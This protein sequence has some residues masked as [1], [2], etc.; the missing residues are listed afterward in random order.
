MTKKNA[1]FNTKHVT[2][3]V[4]LLVSV[5]LHA[6]IHEINLPNPKPAVPPPTFTA[7]Y[8]FQ[9]S[10]AIGAGVAE[11]GVQTTLANVIWDWGVAPPGGVINNKTLTIQG[12][13]IT[14]PADP[15]SS[16]G[17]GPNVTI[18]G[19]PNST[20]GFTFNLI[21]AD[22]VDPTNSVN[23]QFSVIITQ[24][25]DVA[26]VLDR[27]GS[28]N[29][30]TSSGSRWSALQQTVGNFMNLYQTSN[31]TD[32]TTVTYFSTDALPVSTCCG[33]LLANQSNDLKTKIPTEL[34]QPAFQPNGWTAMGKGMKNAQTKLSDATKAR[35]I[36]LITDGE[37]NQDPKVNL[38][39]K[40]YSDNTSIPGGPNPGGIRVCAIGIGSPSGLFHQ[41]LQNLA[42][43]NRGT[44]YVS[45]NGTAFTF[46]GGTNVGDMS[47]GFT[48]NFVQLLQNLSP[49]IIKISAD[50]I[51]STNTPVTLQTFALNKNVDKLMLEFVV[52]KKFEGSQIFQLLL[53]IKIMKDGNNVLGYVAP[54]YTGYTNTLLLTIDFKKQLPSLPPLKPEGNWTISIADSLLKIGFCKLTSIADDHR[55]HMKREFQNKSPKVNDIFPI[56]YML[57]LLGK[58][59]TDAKVEAIILRPGE[60][61]GDLLAKNSKVVQ[62]DTSQDKGSPGVQKYNDLWNSDSAFRNALTRSQNL[63][64]LTHSANGKYSGTFN[65]LTVAGIYHVIYHITGNNIDMGQY[66]RYMVESFY[67]SF[68]NVDMGKSFV[69][70]V[71][72]NG[73]L[74]MDIRPFTTYGRFVGPAMGNAF[75]VSNTGIQISKV[76]DHQDG[77]YTLTFTGNISDTTKLDL[78]GQTIYTGKLEDASKV[79]G[80]LSEWIKKL[81]I[82]VWLFW[83]IVILL[84]LLILW[85]LF[86]KK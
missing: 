76:V 25:T 62:V 71:I 45:D 20:T 44:Y 19:S 8:K 4:T 15:G 67:T 61:L 72:Q 38:D 85:L 86:R 49:Q 1:L 80:G 2:L 26:L 63:L 59:I 34:L 56:D 5:I 65:G 78:L 60:D 74:V 33:N 28:M 42:L 57:D 39:G 79:G 81:G 58:P 68:S 32:R 30:P 43:N 50:N 54:S 21:V 23:G 14:L 51:P 29:E 55:L 82:P 24:P 48:A 83:L 13:T 69:K 35:N 17:N 40:G 27:S 75:T 11:V 37:Q 10:Q 73:T 46:Q 12:L 22:A 66:E 53:R 9:I 77:S 7:E 64:T 52:G 41:T 3:F 31:P 36:L 47:T 84:I 18:L 16:V 6:Q 70:T